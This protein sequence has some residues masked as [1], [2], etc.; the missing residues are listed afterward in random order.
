MDFYLMKRLCALIEISFDSAMFFQPLLPGEKREKEYWEF[1][2]IYG[3]VASFV[4][5]ALIAVYRPDKK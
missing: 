1:P 2:F 3:S 5:I 4:M